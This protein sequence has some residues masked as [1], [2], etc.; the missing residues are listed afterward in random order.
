M[1]TFQ[2]YIEQKENYQLPHSE[3]DTTGRTIVLKGHCY[4]PLCH[5]CA[6]YYYCRGLRQGVKK[7]GYFTVRLTVSV[8]P[9]PLTVSFL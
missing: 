1:P 3:L 6:Y 4:D 9:P 8:P 2:N 7:S 5:M